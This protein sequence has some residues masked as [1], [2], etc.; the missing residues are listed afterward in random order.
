MGNNIIMITRKYLELYY[1]LRSGNC[2]SRVSNGV[3]SEIMLVFVEWISFMGYKLYNCSD[4]L[5][6]LNKA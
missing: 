5:P 2:Q 3:N 6:L 1:L 4:F